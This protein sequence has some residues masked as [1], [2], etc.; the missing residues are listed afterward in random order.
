MSCQCYLLCVVQRTV[1]DAAFPTTGPRPGTGLAALGV[2]HGAQL[3][4]CAFPG[5]SA[6][7]LPTAD[8]PDGDDRSDNSHKRIVLFL[9][10]LLS[11][12]KAAEPLHDSLWGLLGKR[13]RQPALS[14]MLELCR[15]MSGGHSYN[16][17]TTAALMHCQ[18]ERVAAMAALNAREVGLQVAM[19]QYAQMM[20]DLTKVGAQMMDALLMVALNLARKMAERLGPLACHESFA[21]AAARLTATLPSKAGA[22]ARQR[23]QAPRDCRTQAPVTDR[24]WAL[25]AHAARIPHRV[26][27]RT[28]GLQ[29]EAAD[30]PADVDK[31]DST[32]KHIE[33]QLVEEFAQWPLAYCSQPLWMLLWRVCGLG[34]LQR[35]DAIQRLCSV[36]ALRQV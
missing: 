5:I 17:A 16:L 35:A 14:M 25:S 11:D 33:I 10:V 22:P 26:W 34:V 13:R 30:C 32:H 21:G 4:S 12:Q 18:S 15:S 29:L 6:L 3:H 1:S 7:P 20:D 8:G 28:S 31:L 36:A 9:L 19:G 23:H 2:L 24:P 27:P